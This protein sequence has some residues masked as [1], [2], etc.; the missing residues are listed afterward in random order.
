MDRHVRTD[1]AL[2]LRDDIEESYPEGIKV[3][4]NSEM[5]GKIIVTRIEVENEKAMKIYMNP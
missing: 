4:T 2:E 5:D 3:Y 1:L